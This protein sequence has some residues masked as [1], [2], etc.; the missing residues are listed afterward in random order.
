MFKLINNTPENVPTS[1]RTL[2]FKEIG[3]QPFKDT[4]LSKLNVFQIDSYILNPAMGTNIYNE[5]VNSSSYFEIW[6]IPTIKNPLAN[7]DNLKEKLNIERNLQ[8]QTY[9]EVLNELTE[10]LDPDFTV[11]NSYLVVTK[12]NSEIITKKFQE[13][14]IKLRN[15]DLEEAK[16][17]TVL[18]GED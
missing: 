9:L 10:D 4:D 17:I 12:N 15:I 8:L 18:K 3:L 14:S 11:N 7:I 1:F 6:V 2:V 5:F 16:N 13:L